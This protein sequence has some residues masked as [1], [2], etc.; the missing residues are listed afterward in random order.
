M[1]L[2]VNEIV[3]QLDEQFLPLEPMLRGFRLTSTAIREEELARVSQELQV[4]IPDHFLSML[5]QYDFGYFTLGPIAFC[6]S[7]DYLRWIVENNCK[8][9]SNQYPWWDSGPRPIDRLLIANS[10]PYAILLNT[11][12]GAVSAFIHGE[13]FDHGEEIV[14]HDFVKFFRGIGTVFLQRNVNDDNS[15]LADNVSHSVGGKEKSRVWQW[16]A[17]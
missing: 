16:L 10:D 8:S 12:T 4:V 6:N 3:K 9:A 15:C 7:G 5:R 11:S 17:E 13:S 14:A 1:L 2:D